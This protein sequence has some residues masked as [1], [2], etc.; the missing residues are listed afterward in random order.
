MDFSP[1]L[2]EAYAFGAVALPRWYHERGTD[3]P[4]K[5]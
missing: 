2:P 5:P 1:P 4:G 3:G